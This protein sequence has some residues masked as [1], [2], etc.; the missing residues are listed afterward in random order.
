MLIQT[1]GFALEGAVAPK[2]ANTVV[3]LVEVARVGL[4]HTKGVSGPLDFPILAA[5]RGLPA[6]LTQNMVLELQSGLAARGVL[7]KGG[8]TNILSK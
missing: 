4:G 6:R 5:A 3:C 7:W 8:S 2:V 1:L